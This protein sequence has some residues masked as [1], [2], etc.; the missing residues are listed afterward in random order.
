LRAASWPEHFLIMEMHEDQAPDVSVAARRW[1]LT[2]RQTQ[3]LA[4]L[5]RGLPNKAIA[6]ELGCATHTVELHVSAILERALCWSRAEVI[7]K[8]QE[9]QQRT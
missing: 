5:V 3:V 7:T 9:L 8:V 1:G 4:L 2:P 6:S